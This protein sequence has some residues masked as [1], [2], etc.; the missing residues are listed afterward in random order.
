[1]D[2]GAARSKKREQ[3][4]ERAAL[5]AAEEK[6]LK[7][8]TGPSSEAG[9][10]KPRPA[11]PLPQKK[12]RPRP[13]DQSR[14]PALYTAKAVRSNAA[15]NWASGPFQLPPP[16]LEGITRVDLTG[17]G[18]TD[19]SWLAGSGVRW[20]GLSGCVIKDWSAVGSLEQLT[21]ELMVCARC[22][23]DDSV[24]HQRMSTDGSANGSKRIEEPQSSGSY[25]Q[26]LEDNLGGRSLFMA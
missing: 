26:P 14:D 16:S 5:R 2:K 25:E 19:V 7:A 12:Q 3:Q 10:S 24:E 21:G 17:S 18:V 13:E 23:A 1:M 8:K 11:K 22:W 6:R 9:P 4:L 15:L 20:L